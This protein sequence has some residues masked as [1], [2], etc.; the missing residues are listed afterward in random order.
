MGRTIKVFNNEVLMAYGKF[1]LANI[2]M[3]ESIPFKSVMIGGVPAK[4][5][6]CHFNARTFTIENS[7][8][9]YQDGWLCID[10]GG[11]S[12][13]MTF[14]AHTI[15]HSDD[16]LKFDV[17]PYE[18]LDPPLFLPSFLDE[19]SFERACNFLY[20]TKGSS[21]FTISK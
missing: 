16:G 11:D 8:Y 1:L 3:A 9:T 5:R 21:T 19:E 12:P 6:E 7:G 2:S 15:V 20:Q 13:L 14:A 10:G 4:K 17:T 18:A